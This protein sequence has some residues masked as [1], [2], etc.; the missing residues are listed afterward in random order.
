[1]TV[2]LDK[3]VALRRNPQYLTEKQNEALRKSIERDGFLAPVV[4][5]Q[6]KAK[7][8]LYEILSGNHRVI[9][10]GEAGLKEIPA[11][12]VHPCDDARAARIAV[13]MNTVHGEPTPELLA[14][15]LADMEDVVLREVFMDDA[16]LAGLLDFDDT[17]SLRLSE[18]QLPD[19]LNNNSNSSTALNCCCKCG[20]RHHAV[21]PKNSRSN[22]PKAESTSGARK[23]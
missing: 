1:M 15:F 16:L 7:K 4:I 3:L 23:S 12:L 5:R 17:L 9:A 8:G 14:P 6:K 20:H 19:D 21:V 22:K 11:V 18:L 13:N 2:S 10:S